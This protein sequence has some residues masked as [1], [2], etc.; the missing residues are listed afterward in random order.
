[1]S[2]LQEVTADNLQ[3]YNRMS[4]IKTIGEAITEV[5]AA[6]LQAVM[7]I[8]GLLVHREENSLI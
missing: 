2:V 8:N 5:L 4:K 1:M 7:V 3:A 6:P